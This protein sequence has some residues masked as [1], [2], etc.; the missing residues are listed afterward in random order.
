[1]FELSPPDSK[2]SGEVL[3][4]PR[5]LSTVMVDATPDGIALTGINFAVGL[6]IQNIAYLSH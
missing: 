2:P 1:M 4:L 3:F 5:R 6:Q